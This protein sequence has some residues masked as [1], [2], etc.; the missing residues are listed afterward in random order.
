MQVGMIIRRYDTPLWRQAA[1]RSCCIFDD[2]T[3]RTVFD[4]RALAKGLT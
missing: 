3:I 1:V 2:Q 4:A